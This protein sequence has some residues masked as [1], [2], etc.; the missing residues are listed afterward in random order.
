MEIARIR[1]GISGFDKLIQGGFPEGS[2]VMVSGAPGTG[3]SIFGLEY[4]YHGAENG[5]KGIYISIL[6]KI[7]ELMLQAEIFGRYFKPLISDNKIEM[8]EVNLLEFDPSKIL[9]LIKQGNYERVVIDS[10]SNI[11]Y[12]PVDWKNISL[13]YLAIRDIEN[14]IP[15]PRNP[16]VAAK[17]IMERFLIELKKIGATSLVLSES[18]PQR[19]FN[20]DVIPESTVDGVIYL[21]YDPLGPVSGRNLVIQKMRSTKHSESIHPLQIVDGLGLQVLNP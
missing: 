18:M 3:K 9:R 15:D 11:M 14:V 4:I 17:I 19:D 21:N 12:H 8:V 13:T 20:K 2:T 1:T 6:Q 7:S 10:L 16:E 5:Q